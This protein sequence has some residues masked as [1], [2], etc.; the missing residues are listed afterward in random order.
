MLS[1][2]LELELHSTKHAH[3]QNE[4]VQF[5]DGGAPA[6]SGQLLICVATP[7]TRFSG[8]GCCYK[9]IQNAS[10]AFF[11]VLFFKSPKI[12]CTQPRGTQNCY[13]SV[14]SSQHFSIKK[15][16]LHIYE[17][18]NWATLH[19]RGSVLNESY[20][21]IIVRWNASWTKLKRWLTISYRD[22]Y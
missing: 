17:I 4:E 13:H 10:F 9:T 14:W 15:K 19:T 20:S 7:L 11:N 22:Y 6:I 21:S 12:S 8:G 3:T 18:Q 16:A 5:N 2:I 1:N